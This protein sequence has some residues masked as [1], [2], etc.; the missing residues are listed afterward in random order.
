[1]KTDMPNELAGPVGVIVHSSSGRIFFL[2]EEEAKKFEVESNPD[3]EAF[4]NATSQPYPGPA[5]PASCTGRLK[6]LL[7][8]NSNIQLWREN[9]VKWINLCS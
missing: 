4:N 3:F 9:S 6:W 5:Q 8:H 7:S 2:P 1:M